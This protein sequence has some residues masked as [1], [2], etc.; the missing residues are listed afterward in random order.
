MYMGQDIYRHLHVHQCRQQYLFS[1]LILSDPSYSVSLCQ[2]TSPPSHVFSFLP[3][4]LLSLPPS[5]LPPSLWP[6]SLPLAPLPPPTRGKTQE[7]SQEISRLS[8]EIVTHQKE[9]AAYLSYE[10]RYMQSHMCSS[11]G[12]STRQ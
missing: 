7:L 8:Q 1:S 12:S 6:L 2:I 11:N 5:P 4:P 3:S 9:N 10:Q